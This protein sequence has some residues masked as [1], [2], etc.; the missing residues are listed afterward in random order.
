MTETPDWLDWEARITKLLPVSGSPSTDRS[1]LLDELSMYARAA[2][3]EARRVGSSAP[4]VA[5][6]ERAMAWLGRPVFVC[7]HHRSGTT[8]LNSLLDGHPEL[9]VLPNEGT[10]FTSFR[11]AARKDPSP[12][13]IDR[14][15]ADW[16]SR[17][18]DPNYEPHF[19]LGRA[20]PAGSPSVF[21]ARRL[22]GWHSALLGTSAAR[23]QFALLLS[24]VAAF[25]DLVPTRGTPRLWVEKTP[26][27]ERQVGRLAVFSDARFIQVVR[28]P[29]ATLASLLPIYRETEG[30]GGVAEHA[31]SIGRS[32]R[33]AL[34][35]DRVLREQYLIVRYEDLVAEP[36]REMDRV[37]AFLG[38][39][40]N[41]TLKVPT[42][43]GVP[44]RSNSSFGPGDPGVIS[45]SRATPPLSP[46]EEMLIGAFTASAA[47]TFGYEVAA[48]PALRGGVHR[49]R[50]EV[51]HFSRAVRRRIG[52]VRRAL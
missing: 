39:C 20:G 14:F 12:D 26:L 19:Q 3:R 4:G 43:V 13:D 18:V 46:I 33:L 34:R 40:S 41:P 22:L 37:C 7:G 29:A 50:V 38:I 47:R 49:L 51:A 30:D 2:V 45:R 23:A 24:L 1:L 35:N 52:N 32:L 48:P 28:H 31:R 16:I 11:Y 21:F 17:F 9:V 44:A 42:V 5:E 10:Y 8:L 25:H 36:A 27:N 6:R 15:A